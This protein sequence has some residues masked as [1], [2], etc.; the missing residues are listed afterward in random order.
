MD[1]SSDIGF[2]EFIKPREEYQFWSSNAN[3]GDGWIPLLG[4][5]P[6]YPSIV[7]GYQIQLLNS[8]A[9]RQIIYAAAPSDLKIQFINPQASSV[10]TNASQSLSL[11][12]SFSEYEIED[13]GTWNGCLTPD[14]EEDFFESFIREFE[15]NRIQIVRKKPVVNTIPESP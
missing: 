2:K 12:D 4:K 14:E 1:V 15:E 3:G 13:D 10:C 9:R 11:T 7:D 6:C 8:P 5:A